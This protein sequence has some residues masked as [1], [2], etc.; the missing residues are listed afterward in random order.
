MMDRS[1]EQNQIDRVLGREEVGD[2]KGVGHDLQRA[3][4]ELASQFV[5]RTATVEQQRIVVFHE[6]CGGEGDESF[7]LPG[8]VVIG[9]LALELPNS[10]AGASKEDAAVGSFGFAGFLE[11]FQ[12]ATDG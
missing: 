8:L 1:T 9:A 5:G 10:R 4:D 12:I 3:A 7:L 2:R 6:G 11:R